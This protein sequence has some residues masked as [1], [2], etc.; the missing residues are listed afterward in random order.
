MEMSELHNR[1]LIYIIE[2]CVL[3]F[4]LAIVPSRIKISLIPI[5]CLLCLSLICAAGQ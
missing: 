3:Q 2:D 1:L 4:W 5:T